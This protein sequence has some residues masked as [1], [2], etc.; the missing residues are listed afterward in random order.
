MVNLLQVGHGAIVGN[1]KPLVGAAPP[2]SLLGE[3]LTANQIA[4]GLLVLAGIAVASRQ[5]AWTTRT[6]PMASKVAPASIIPAV[7][8]SRVLVPR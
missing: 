6:G 3:P 7:A 2:V 1:L 8:S 4:G 5:R